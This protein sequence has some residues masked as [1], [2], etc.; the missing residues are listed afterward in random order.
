MQ[1]N[2]YVLKSL[3]VTYWKVKNEICIHKRKTTSYAYEDI[4]IY[5][6]S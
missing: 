1:S 3:N 6:F 5:K 2:V 4:S